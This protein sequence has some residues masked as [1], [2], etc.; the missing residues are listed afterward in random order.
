MLTYEDCVEMSGC[1]EDIVVAIA[2]H[3]HLHR[4]LA[5]AEAASIMHDTNGRLRLRRIIVDDIRHARTRGD[6]A[7]ERALR[8]LL[9][10]LIREQPLRRRSRRVA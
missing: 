6:Q 5:S 3:E 8:Q 9:S 7:H 10:Q 1:C 2:E 4:L